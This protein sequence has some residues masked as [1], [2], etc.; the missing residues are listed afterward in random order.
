MQ[1]RHISTLIAAQDG[2]AK[3]T[4]LAW[5]RNHAKL[6]VV[7]VDRVVVLFDEMGEKRDKFS[8]KP[9]DSQGPKNYQVKGMAFSPDSTKLAIA[10]SDNIVFVYKLGAEW[11]E[12]KSICNK[13]PQQS[14]VTCL[15]WPHQHA[16][17]VVFGLADGK[18]RVG[19]LKTNKSQT[20]FSTESM[21]VSIAASPDGMGFVSGH[22][23]GEI[24]RFFFD[25][26]MMG[27]Q[28][29]RLATHPCPPYALAW[30]ETVFAA[31]CDMRIVSY[32]N[33]GRIQQQFDYSRDETEREFTA[34]EVS[35]SGQS[36]VVGS[37]NRLRVFNYSLRKNSWEEGGVKTIE[38]L[39]TV[40]SLSWKYDG[41]R[42]AVG[43]LC[44]AVE[45]FDCCLRRARYKGKFEFTYVGPS[46][47][48]VKRL[49]S[50][51]RI[52]LKSHYGYEISKV[53]VF[54]D[55]F[56]IAHT[57]DTLLMGDMATCKLSEV[58]WRGSG[59]EKFYFDNPHVCMIFNAGEL[60]IIEYGINE[61][62]GS[63]L[64]EHM[65]PRLLSVRIN[66]R[67]RRNDDDNKKIAYLVDLQTIRVLDLV[68]GLSLA[69]VAHDAR[70]DWL[71]MNGSGR[72]LL[73]RDKR[74]QLHLFDI[75]TEAR[76]TLLNYCSYVQWVPDSDVVVAQN[77]GNL[78]IWYSI[79]SPERVSMFPI[80][81]E[82]E[83]IERADGRT[84]VIVN[85]GVNSVS[86][87][88]DEGLIEFGT[89][90]EDGNF[91]RAVAFLETLEMTPETE[92]M[93][94]T[95]AQLSLAD[96]Q[97]DVSERC[98]SAL[99]DIARA[100]YLRNVNRVAEKAAAEGHGDGRDNYLVRARLAVLDKKF[101]AAESIFLENS[102]VEEAMDMYQQLHRWDDS[103]AIAEAKGHPELETLRRNY[104]QWL[105]DT[106]QEEKA[107]QMK[108]REK[109]YAAAI[110]L[111]MRAGLPARAAQVV[112][113]HEGLLGKSDLL[114]RIAG[115][116]LK[117]GLYE[118]AGELFEKLRMNPRALECYRKGH[119]YRRAVDLSRAAFPTEVVKLEEEWGDYLVRQKQMDSAIN[120]YIEA[121]SAVKAI[122]AA[123]QSRQWN[124]AV[125][126]VEMQE[127]NTA[128]K[129]YREIAGHFESVADFD[130]AERYY[131]RCGQPMEAIRMHTRANRWEAA[132]KL[133]LTCMKPQQVVDLCIN[134]AQEM[135]AQGKYREAERLYITVEEPDLAINMYKKARQYDEMIRLVTA[136]HKNL[137]VETHLHLAKELETEG[138]YRL[139]E[140]HYCAGKDWK[141]AVNMYRANDMWDDAYRVAKKEGGAN[142][143]KQVA[144]LWAKSLGG[145]SA[146]KLLTKFGLLEQAI[147]YAA[148]NGAF[149]FAFDLCRSAMKSRLPDIHL[150]HAMFL[151]DEGTFREAEEEFIRAGKPRE[152]VLMY[153][154]NQDWQS[155]QRVAESYDPSSV[156]DVLVG[157]GKAALE[158][159]EF[160]RAETLL[161]RAQ[162]LEVAIAFYKEH[163]LWTDALRV[164]KEYM[165]HKLPELHDDYDRHLSEAASGSAGR[166]ALVAPARTWEANG[167]YSRAIDAYLK[168]NTEHTADMDFLEGAWEKAVEL[169]MKFVPDRAVDA[170]STVSGRL[171]QIKRFEAA[172]ELYVGVEM[173][174]DAIDAY[175]RGSCWNK[176]RACASD[177][178]PQFRDYVETAYV[179]H[180]K[181]AGHAEKLV[182][183]DVIAGLDMFVQRGEWNKCIEKAQSQGAEVLG[184]YVALYAAHLIKEKN[185]ETA[186]S[187]FN[188]HGAPPNAQNFNIYKRLAAEV[189]SKCGFKGE[190][191][192]FGVL[193]ELKAILHR[194]VDAMAQNGESGSQ[195]SRE[196]ERLLFVAHLATLRAKCGEKD[197]LVSFWGK[198]S[199]AMLRY[200]D[201]I[202]ADKAFYEAGIAAKTCNWENLA[203][204]FLNRY[205][206]LS[207]AIEEGTLEMLE[208]S[209]FVQTDIPFEVPLP[210]HQCLSEA[211][212]EEVREWVLAISMD[213]QVDQTL[214]RKPCDGCGAGMYEASLVCHNCK[215]R[216]EPC[217][218][219]GYPV[220]R[221]RVQCK[222]CNRAANKD[223][224]NKF[225][226]SERVCPWCNDTQS[227]SFAIK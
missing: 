184:K 80:K 88:L 55:Q 205:L 89:A 171:I 102:G 86:Y 217:I 68:T 182:D 128:Q 135:E 162:K 79:D 42:L 154:H 209:D 133:A 59:N 92:A 52:V 4:A 204:V 105:L 45:L 36:I 178:C 69:D 1:L 112:A 194:L 207:E 71:E 149:D 140:Q 142:L 176:A 134:Q 215:T 125:Q 31:G 170:V 94:R 226:M 26:S 223:D 213:Q 48:I 138:N 16:N 144:F 156:M 27:A 172:A 22:A 214:S 198:I 219:T 200:T 137:L 181:S 39:Y 114:E 66:E 70:I 211:K 49:S 25:E 100:R 6:A 91:E 46:Q 203:F 41:S 40:S 225:V 20:L 120:H 65:N 3:I 58:A 76:T 95:L 146:I 96:R 117:A 85:E 168:L 129:Y 11:G 210:E 216:Y 121:G 113:Q 18:V 227:P 7:G 34:A 110:N 53:N 54:Q 164:A 126:I 159:K 28:Q 78:C 17:T 183:V 84:E 165:P 98:Y 116:L 163:N 73:F 30:G 130:L 63:V 150:K 145:D 208:N 189:L 21:V 67:R 119:A 32:D 179:K 75:A 81:G 15:V 122:E 10:Q 175:I 201:E 72:K 197:Q 13:Y 160:G 202:P 131:V 190:G 35:P 124:K 29:G 192:G 44:G 57:S 193:R 118:R 158:K 212:R 43:T 97:L 50:G 177:Y 14:P 157:Q 87:A 185:V 218:V 136:Y 141:G 155:A 107:G 220:L 151:E 148:D 186:I 111:Y 74:R 24:Y 143:A 77:R 51:T 61:I 224:W 104:M 127:P 108:E 132:H 47:V 19:N 153:V 56:L 38:N 174:K 60:S 180:L 191:Y 5:S 83:N 37:F 93:W 90:I 82:V 123:I 101:K 99:G 8:T 195:P 199:V 64:T 221:S 9:A 103:I 167:E 109:D 187:L 152:A 147:D 139:A 196:F 188:K 161:L 166:D 115:A 62:L 169:A 23:N 33:D 12:K 173:F 106:G 222:S 206:D 2:P